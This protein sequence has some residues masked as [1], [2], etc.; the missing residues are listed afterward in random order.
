MKKLQ[1]AQKA[2]CVALTCSIFIAGCG[3]HEPR[4]IKVRQPGDD[5]MSCNSLATTMSNL[6]G[7][8]AQKEKEKAERDTWNVIE[9]V[10]GFFLIV[11]WF[12]MDLK[13]SHEAEIAAFQARKDALKLLYAD[14]NCPTGETTN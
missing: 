14:K 13:K 12:F 3:G 7:Q 2:L 1:W 9:F 8:I 11:P 4:P 6:D 5:K 10:S